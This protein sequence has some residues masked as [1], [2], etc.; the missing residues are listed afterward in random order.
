MNDDFTPTNHP[1][2]WFGTCVCL[3]IL[4]EVLGVGTNTSATVGVVVFLVGFPLTWVG[5]WVE[6]AD[7]RITKPEERITKKR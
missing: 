1:L 6:R 5:K 7:E 4:L 2:K 3:T